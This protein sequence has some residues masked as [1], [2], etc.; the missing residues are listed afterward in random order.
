MKSIRPARII[1]LVL[2]IAFV[3][4]SAVTSQP[5]DLESG[6]EVRI[7]WETTDGYWQSPYVRVTVGEVIGGNSMTIV[8][9]RGPN[10]LVVPT[11]SVRTLERRVGTRPASA[12]AI[13]AGSAIGFAAG[14]AVGAL[15][16]A[17][18]PRVTGGANSGIT[19]GILLGAPAGA[20]VAYLASRQRPIYESISLPERA[21]PT[22]GVDAAGRFGFGLRIGTR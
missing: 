6:E 4:P 16:A 19:A 17:V 22:V 3:L 14:F 5:T 15:R 20:F 21:T 12:P 1:M 8:V 13:A 9:Q 2:A 7:R 11:A 10:V 18:N